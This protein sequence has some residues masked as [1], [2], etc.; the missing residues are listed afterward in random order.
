MV[1]KKTETNEDKVNKQLA[2]AKSLLG[3]IEKLTKKVEKM[4]AKK[5]VKKDVR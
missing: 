2:M 4:T 3:T 1:K 5:E